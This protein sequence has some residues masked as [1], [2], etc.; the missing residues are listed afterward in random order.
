M[1]P[2]DSTILEPSGEDSM[3]IETV[4]S[5]VTREERDGPEAEEEYFLVSGD[6]QYPEDSSVEETV[7]QVG[8]DKIEIKETITWTDLC[9]ICATVNDQLIPIFEGEGVDHD[10]SNK[11]L[12]HLPIHVCFYSID[13]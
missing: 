2:R 1:E 4:K 3:L 11:I 10:L 7:H 9:R 13:L 8:G 5:I 12:K 6:V